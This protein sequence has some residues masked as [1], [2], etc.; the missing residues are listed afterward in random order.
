MTKNRLKCSNR[1]ILREEAED[2]KT[3]FLV[4]DSTTMLMSLSEVL[5]K[6]G[7]QVETAANGAEALNQLK[8]GLK[9][10]L[11]ITDQNMPAFL[12]RSVKA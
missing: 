2:V 6:A 5:K 9:P 7:F 10:D 8:T 4:D 3:I 12:P 1:A 11:I